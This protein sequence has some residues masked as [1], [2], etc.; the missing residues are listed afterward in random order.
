M[1]Q[2]IRIGISTCPNDTFAFHGL[3]DRCVD[4]RGL[5]FKIE[6]HDIQELNN[7]IVNQYFDVAKASFYAAALLAEKY[8][9]L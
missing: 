3:M 2:T 8:V 6:L 1:K 9:V 4:W 5:D 7:R